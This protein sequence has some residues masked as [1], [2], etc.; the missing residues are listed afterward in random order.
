M[1]KTVLQVASIALSYK[2]L[3]C[4][5]SIDNEATYSKD[6]RMSSPTV[7]LLATSDTAN[8]I[9]RF[10][11]SQNNNVLE[12]LIYL[13]SHRQP[14]AHTQT[15]QLTRFWHFRRFVRVIKKLAKTPAAG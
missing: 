14:P 7:T 15:G 9:E 3:H 6:I 10:L 2:A 1:P 4:I 5:T 13:T 11:S 12:E 8:Y